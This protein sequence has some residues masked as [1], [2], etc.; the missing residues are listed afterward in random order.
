MFSNMRFA[1]EMFTE[2]LKLWFILNAKISHFLNFNSF[3]R[4]TKHTS[5]FL[6]KD[7]ER[8]I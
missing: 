5:N 8:R 6:E 3:Q 7:I 1:Y 4:D 2:S